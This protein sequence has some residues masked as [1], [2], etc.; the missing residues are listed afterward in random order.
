MEAL[1]LLRGHWVPVFWQMVWTTGKF[2]TLAFHTTESVDGDASFGWWY[3]V[4][5]D[6]D[7]D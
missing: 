2:P 1:A 3:P 7:D 5:D 4:E 6:G